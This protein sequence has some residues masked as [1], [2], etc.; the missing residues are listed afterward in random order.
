MLEQIG[1]YQ[2]QGEIARGGMGVVYRGFDPGLNRAVAIKVIL[3]GKNARPVQ[4][5]RFAREANLLARLEHRHIVRVHAAGEEHGC[6]YLVLDLVEG[7]SLEA[8]LRGGALPSVEAARIARRLADALSYAHERGVLHRDLK[9]SNVLLREGEPL[10]TDFGLAKDMDSSGALTKS[11]HFMGSRGYCAPEQAMGKLEEVGPRSDVYGLGATLYAMLTGGLAPH[12]GES[13][14]E[15]IVATC[16]RN[17]DPPSEVNPE[18]DA[19]L[20]RICLRCLEREPAER[21]ASAA[22]LSADLERYLSGERVGKA[23]S[24]R[25][26]VGIAA[27]AA[28]ALG[29]VTALRTT[30][31]PR[32]KPTPP[33]AQTALA[34]PAPESS[35]EPPRWFAKELRDAKALLAD[36]P[37]RA[38]H[39]LKEALGRV[40]PLALESARA[41]SVGLLES[42]LAEPRRH[43]GE[44]RLE[45]LERLAELDPPK[46]ASYYHRRSLEYARPV[47]QDIHRSVQELERAIAADEGQAGRFVEA[48]FARLGGSAPMKLLDLLVQHAPSPAHVLARGR[49]RLERGNTTDALEDC[50]TLFKIAPAWGHLL[51]ARVRLQP[52]SDIGRALEDLNQALALDPALAEAYG[53]RASLYFKRYEVAKA[54]ADY[55]KLLELDPKNADLH[56]RARARERKTAATEGCDDLKRRASALQQERD[57]TGALVL[58]KKA[59]ALPADENSLSW[60]HF[61]IAKV[62]R[63]RG[64][65]REAI[66]SLTR[67]LELQELSTFALERGALKRE[68]GRLSAALADYD[69]AFR[70][71]ETPHPSPLIGRADCLLKLGRLAEAKATIARAFETDLVKDKSFRYMRA[72][73]LTLSG[74]VKLAEKDWEGA[75]RDFES[76]ATQDPRPGVEERLRGGLIRLDR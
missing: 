72:E 14:V 18:V 22:E 41:A 53:L 48:T 23:G 32:E 12:R 30:P 66:A 5:E 60:I 50:E 45:V 16:E 73:L 13:L 37:V 56:Q 3:V 8:V 43:E 63:K 29:L 28:L 67:A 44:T 19:S 51:R 54:E 42:A 1:P 52:V 24:W 64:R 17:P 38:A 68:R 20:E 2:V 34:S 27:G 6:P 4:T 9:P 69:L 62:L 36:D 7:P 11:G 61:Q 47:G 39:R 75:R 31:P 40:G 15:L 33:P 26:G 35:S 65:L 71:D 10:L 59:A 74:E 58:L 46:A 76:A 70:L 57:F 49:R 55:A 25:W 21:Y